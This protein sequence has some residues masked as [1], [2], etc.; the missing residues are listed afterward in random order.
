[1]NV[2]VEFVIDERGGTVRKR[3]RVDQQRVSLATV[4]VIEKQP[5]SSNGRRGGEMDEF[6]KIND[7]AFLVIIFDWCDLFGFLEVSSARALFWS[8]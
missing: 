6:S 2:E 8:G 7:G 3:D 1:M 5:E 4:D